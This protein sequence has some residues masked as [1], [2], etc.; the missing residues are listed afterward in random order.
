M[1]PSSKQSERGPGG[2]KYNRFF[3]KDITKKVL[4]QETMAAPRQMSQDVHAQP[5]P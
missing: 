5:Q 2:E 3:A 4:G 1:R